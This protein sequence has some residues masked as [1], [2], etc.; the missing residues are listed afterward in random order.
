MAGP[1]MSNVEG[2]RILAEG[3]SPAIEA[4]ALLAELRAKV[5]EQPLAQ[6]SPVGK[7]L[8]DAIDFLLE[9]QVGKG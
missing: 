5:A 2:E 7:V 4:Q 6:F 3:V 1:D 9:Q 8:I